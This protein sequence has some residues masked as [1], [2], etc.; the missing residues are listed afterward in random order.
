M[1]NISFSESQDPSL[2]EL[3]RLW[4]NAGYLCPAGER[5][6]SGYKSPQT[7]I[8]TFQAIL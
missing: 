3:M 6:R 7:Q 1:I 2:V 8:K 5:D 4:K